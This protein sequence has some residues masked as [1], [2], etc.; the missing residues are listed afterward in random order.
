MENP[1]YFLRLALPTP[2]NKLF[3]YLPPQGIDHKALIPGLRVKV[4]FQSRTMVGLLIDV[5]KKTTVPLEKLKR[6]EAV[7]DSEPLL[8]ADLFALCQFASGYYHYPLGEVLM[9]AFP[10]LLRKGKPAELKRAITLTEEIVEK[11]LLLNQSQT[12]ALQT[13][14]ENVDVFKVFL[15]EGVT[16]SGKTEVYL[17]SIAHQLKFEKQILVLVPEIN[18]TPQTI[19][20]FRKRF[21]VPMA[22][23]HSGL[24]ERERLDAWLHAKSGEI[25][26]VIGT[27]SAIFTPF[28][29][30]GL[31][32][33]DEEH[34]ASFK[35]QDRF[36]Y[37]ARDLSIMRANKLNIPIVLGSATPS[38][39]SLLNVRRK[40]YHYLALPERA[41][42]AVLPIYQLLDV[43][44]D[45]LDEG[46][47][48]R[49]LSAMHEHLDRQN[50]VMLFL[51]RR[52]FAPII[53][54]T[55]CTSILSCKR[56][57]AHLVYHR[58]PPHLKCHYCDA[59]V[60]LPSQCPSCEQNALQP[61]GLGTQRLEQTLKSHFP[62]IPIIRIDRD[63]T[64]RKDAIQ[65]LLSQIHSEEKAILLGTQMLAKGHHFPRVTLVGVVDADSGLFS[66][67]F[68]AAE[69]MGQLLIQ[70][71]GRSGR[72]EKQGCVL[73]QTKHPDHPLLNTLINQDYHHFAE[74]L[75]AEREKAKLPPYSH[76][77][78]LSAKAHHEEN[79]QSFLTNIKEFLVK[80]D[81][82]IALLGPMPAL[83]AKRKGLYCQHLLISADKRQSLQQLLMKMH[84]RLDQ[85]DVIRKRSV[86]WILDVDPVEV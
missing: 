35:Q 21:S 17:Q 54:C 16:G 85:E 82:A 28:A 51:N 4:P 75:L 14:N 39:E 81:S 36:R 43:R 18:L 55:N 53:Y 19:A 12:E 8:P 33:V 13:I 49:L 67:D 83:I 76:M 79:A 23:L 40:R 7:L 22:V 45:Q 64:A 74:A 59:Y 11:P 37:H 56:C 73:I 52:G 77:A 32:I 34:D 6:A 41:G 9:T 25:K 62:H 1:G 46:L 24:T 20:R 70:V 3:D 48:S 68:R 27:R 60:K 72:E 47:S 69:Q 50:Q 38:L 86:K 66:T 78:L 15:L 42:K 5:V 58:S 71:A 84:E 30:L 31:I 26:I 2:L 65:N 63:T 57:D 80:L 44:K 10:S 29:H 61:V